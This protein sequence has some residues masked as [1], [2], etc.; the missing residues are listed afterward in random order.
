MKHISLS[1][2]VSFPFACPRPAKR[3]MYR[4][5]KRQHVSMIRDTSCYALLR[6]RHRGRVGTQR[7]GMQARSL[8]RRRQAAPGGG[9]YKLTTLLTATAE[10]ASEMPLLSV[11]PFT[12]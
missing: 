7:E 8:H 10:R 11:C 5:C 4:S 9:E 3:L 12:T 2:H 6:G 1:S